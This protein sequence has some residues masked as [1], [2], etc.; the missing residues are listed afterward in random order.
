[1]MG[2]EKVYK[3][4]TVSTLTAARAAAKVWVEKIPVGQSMCNS[5]FEQCGLQ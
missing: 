3:L 2:K 1:M 5:F 4:F